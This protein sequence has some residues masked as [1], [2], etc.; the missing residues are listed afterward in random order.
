MR[1][2]CI[3]DAARLLRPGGC[4]VVTNMFYQRGAMDAMVKDSGCFEE[5]EATGGAIWLTF[6]PSYATMYVKRTERP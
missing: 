2:H 4:L 1:R 6:L 5:G 3:Q